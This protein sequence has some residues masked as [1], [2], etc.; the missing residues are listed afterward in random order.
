M[1]KDEAKIKEAFTKTEQLAR[2]DL[3]AAL[4]DRV[5]SPERLQEAAR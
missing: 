4:V 2:R 1:E 5:W 3:V